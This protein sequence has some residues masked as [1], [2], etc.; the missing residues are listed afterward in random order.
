MTLLRNEFQACRV[1]PTEY[2]ITFRSPFCFI[3]NADIKTFMFMHQHQVYETS[4]NI[5]FLCIL[6][7][8][9]T[10]AP[11]GNMPHVRISKKF[12]FVEL[13]IASQRSIGTLSFLTMSL[14]KTNDI[15]AKSVSINSTLRTTITCTIEISNNELYNTIMQKI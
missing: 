1:K 5:C 15:L 12:A 7:I 11:K 3:Q 2:S 9:Y 4:I 10:A 14:K 8:Q 13:Y 6:Y